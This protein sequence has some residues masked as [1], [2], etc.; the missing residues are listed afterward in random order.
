MS[1]FIGN[2]FSL[3]MLESDSILK[4]SEA[5]IS[6]VTKLLQQGFQSCIGHQATS[7]ILTD[8]LNINVPTNRV[9]IKLKKGDT[10]VVF[11]LLTRLEE[12]KVL[13]KEEIQAL[14]YKFFVVEV[15]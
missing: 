10:L 1:K 2:A 8:L 6:T 11:Q 3:A 15:V 4:V 14:P 12:G 13:T 5:D 9:S 7:Q